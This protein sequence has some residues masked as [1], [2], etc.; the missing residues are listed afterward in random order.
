MTKSLLSFVILLSFVV[1][2]IRAQQSEVFDK[3]KFLEMAQQEILLK[4]NPE[5]PREKIKSAG[6]TEEEAIQ[7]ARE[8]NIDLAK[9]LQAGSAAKTTLEESKEEVAQKKAPTGRGSG[10]WYPFLAYLV[11]AYSSIDGATYDVE[12]SSRSIH[13]RAPKSVPCRT[14]K[15]TTRSSI[16]QRC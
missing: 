5:E 14:Q 3:E 13:T 7:L 9:Y 10:G 1:Q 16:T 15:S 4:M 2:P 8:R 12:A 6:L 11:S